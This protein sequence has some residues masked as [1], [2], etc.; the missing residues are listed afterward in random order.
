[1]YQHL[2]A[3]SDIN[4]NPRRVYV[5]IDAGGNIIKAIDEGYSGLPAEC[6]GLIQLP[7]YEVTSKEYRCLLSDFPE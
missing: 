1:M 3:G 5:I 2:T 6:K 7:G 4:D